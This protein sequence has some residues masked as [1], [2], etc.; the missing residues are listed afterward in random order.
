[1]GP[2]QVELVVEAMTEDPQRDPY[3]ALDFRWR[4]HG[5]LDS[6][7]GKADTKASITL[8]IESAVVGFVITLSKH[9]ERLASLEGASHSWYRIGCACLLIAGVFALLVVV[10]QLRRRKSKREWQGNMI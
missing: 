4:V 9:G 8:A 6:W 1:V 7:T 10:P 3:G 2:L 5:A